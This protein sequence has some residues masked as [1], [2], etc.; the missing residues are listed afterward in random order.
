MRQQSAEKVAQGLWKDQNIFGGQ[1]GLDTNHD[2]KVVCRCIAATRL[3]LWRA[4]VMQISH[5]EFC[6]GFKSWLENK[7]AMGEMNN[8]D[9]IVNA[10]LQDAMK[11]MFG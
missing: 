4:A 5:E 8:L 3:T 6:S 2:H 9:A 11:N 1:T 10:Q 7:K